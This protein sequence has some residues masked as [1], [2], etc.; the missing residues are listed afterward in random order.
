MTATF[1]AIMIIPVVLIMIILASG[2]ITVAL[3]VISALIANIVDLII[4]MTR[5]SFIKK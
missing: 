1:L 5:F 2:I 3:A 4:A